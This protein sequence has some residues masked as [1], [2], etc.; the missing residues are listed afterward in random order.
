MSTR[1][2]KSSQSQ[3]VKPQFEGPGPRTRREFLK[4]AAAATAG[5]YAYSRTEA[6][7]AEASNDLV[8]ALIGC[9]GRGQVV[10]DEFAK[11]NNVHIGYVC[12]VD[13]SR[14]SA[15][16]S[17][18]KLEQDQAVNDLRRILDDKSVDAV[19]I[20]TPDHWHAPAAILACQA[21]KHVYVEKPCSHN[22]H[23]GQLL[24]DAAHRSRLVVQHGTQSRSSQFF[25]DAIQLLREGIIGDV[26]VAKAWNVQRRQDIGRK[27]PS[28]PP[29]DLD[30]DLWVGPAPMVPYR[31]NC[32][33]YTWHWWYDF[34]TG[35]LGND[36]CH[37]LDYAA[38]GLGVDTHPI[39]ISA[40]GG[41]YYFNDD[42][43][44]PDTLTAIYEFANRENADKKQQLI[45]EMRL[46]STNYPFNA[47]SGVEFYG[48]K[49][50]MLLSKRGKMEVFDERN[51]RVP[52]LKPRDPILLPVSNHQADFVDAIIHKRPPNAEI[53]VGFRSAALCH[54][55]NIAA[56]VQRVI[57]FDGQE[58]AIIGDAE[59]HR[60]LSRS[61][62][63]GHWA[64]P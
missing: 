51:Q 16:A 47:D 6:S 31:S 50:K 53:E 34:G 45:F 19:I 5:I 11:I 25:A 62:R 37:E 2:R 29:K 23:E 58:G 28:D 17:R 52:N 8:V 27:Q 38:W 30:Y 49:G 9:G 59:A 48:T 12:D 54:L 56:R 3:H 64:V 10:T 43:Q 63:S 15:A 26:L 18:F 60:L 13:A 40:L 14:R 36:G 41:K 20:A 33:H 35:D 32:G 1:K 44:F 61:Y 7:M 22:F 55:G 39:R 46:W 24:V 21:G 42:Q 4:Q 57:Q